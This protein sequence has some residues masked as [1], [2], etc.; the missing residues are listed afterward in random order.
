MIRL[1]RNTIAI[2]LSILLV[3]QSF[4]STVF[5]FG[6]KIGEESTQ[7]SPGVT[8]TEQ[9]YNGSYERAVN[10]LN[11]DLNDPF[12]SLEVSLPNPLTAVTTVSNRAVQNNY[13]G[14][15]VIGAANAG[16]FDMAGKM[17]VNLI[18]ENNKL[19]NIGI[20]GTKGP[21][22][23]TNEPIAFGINRYGKAVIDR[24]KLD[25]VANI[26]GNSINISKIN[27]ERGENAIHLYKSPKQ[28]TG[29]NEW[30]TEIVVSNVM[31]IPTELYV[32][33]TMTGTVSQI[34]RFGEG[35][36][37]A[38]PYDGF[39]ISAHGPEW[40]ERLKNVQVGDM[41]DFQY[42]LGD[43]WQDAQYVIGTGPLLVKNGQVSISMDENQS[44]AK[45]LQ[46]RTAIATNQTGDKVFLV[47]VD[48]RQNGHSNGATLRELADYLISLGAYNAINLDGGGSTAM[49]V[50]A[51]GNVQPTLVNKPS[52]GV[53]RKV[54]SIFQVISSAPT[55]DPKTLKLSIPNGKILKGTPVQLN[56]QYALDQY[57][58][59]VK[60]NASDITLAA[61]GNVG[62]INGMT[63][64][65]GNAGTG[66]ILA[67]YNG[68]YGEVPV[69]VIDKIDKIEIEPKSVVIGT[70]ESIQLTANAI[71]NGGEPIVF[72]RSVIK[73]SVDGNI[74]TITADGK[75]TAGTEKAAGNIIATFENNKA[76]IPVKVGVD[77]VFIDGFE[78]LANWTAEQAKANASVELASGSGDVQE[79]K[80][81]LKLNYDFTTAEEGIKVA[82]AKAKTPIE[83]QGY[84]KELGV[85]VKGD[86][87]GHWLRAHIIDGA[88]KQQTINFTEENG[89][90][91]TGWQYVRAQV[92]AGL[93][94]PLKF[95]R[96]Y[97]AETVKEKQN[98]GAIYFDGL[99]SAYVSNHSPAAGNAGNNGGTGAVPPAGSAENG[100]NSSQTVSF[101]DISNNHWAYKSIAFLSD[102]GIIN[103]YEDG[104]FRP[105]AE[106]TR[107]MAAAMIAREFKLTEASDLPFLFNDV[108]K[109]HYAYNAIKAV[110]EAGII[111]GQQ[112]GKFAPDAKLT[113]AEMAVILTRAYKLEG[114]ADKTF[115]DVKAN[116][117]AATAIDALLANKIT[118]GYEDGS[119]KP[120]K[121]TTRAEFSSFM[122]RVIKFTAE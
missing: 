11:I 118:G 18:A 110:S 65:A 70:N 38:I 68:A 113:R 39:V 117:W 45:S 31:P 50:R 6:T 56:L 99:Q 92:P 93:Q 101:K 48:G 80:N 57:F 1:K 109:S 73:W 121:P 76:S 87:A 4:G 108:K 9:K 63:F 32:G 15:F 120:S 114:A 103:G 104:T 90:T 96:I 85:W 91:W 23:P 35:G 116:H 62:T 115:T 72:D 88:G 20:A 26:A 2:L 59:P 44:F 19:I 61:E 95:D 78:S 112:V 42:S 24:Y 10:L 81:S 89:L 30:G 33:Q 5:A 12:T 43:V 79:G 58:N 16:F 52:E 3:F 74:G 105:S 66:K 21:T 14:H 36:N 29:T 77:P 122:E 41:I 49:T 60:V 106:I 86:G 17:P 100:N 71:Y 83:L 46:P 84:P 55:S 69:T 47:T 22:S 40:S 54:S 111:N 102:R 107:A 94:L 7:V 25:V 27:G 8:Y 13:E 82:Y 34:S 67:S 64:T 51:L 119:F 75:F 53:E 97:V 28:T 37:A 98:K